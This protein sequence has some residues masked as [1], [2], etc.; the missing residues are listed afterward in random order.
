ARRI[1]VELNEKRKA[2][3]IIG[4]DAGSAT[5]ESRL[6]QEVQYRF[7]IVNPSASESDFETY[8]QTIL[9]DLSRQRAQNL[10][11]EKMKEICTRTQC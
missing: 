11:A 5:D 4:C 6:K 9:D 1:C 7:K 8:W 3:R 2:S 10:M